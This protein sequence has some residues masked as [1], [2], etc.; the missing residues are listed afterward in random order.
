MYVV[1]RKVNEELLIG[2]ARVVVLEIAGRQVKL[3]IDAPDSVEV[4][5]IEPRPADERP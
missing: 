3:G 4:R 1:T 5:R 2:E